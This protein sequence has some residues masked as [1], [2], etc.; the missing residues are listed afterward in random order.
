MSLKKG[1]MSK[2]EVSDDMI[3]KERDRVQIRMGNRN[4]L[5]I[6]YLFS[7]KTGFSFS[8][9]T[10]NNKI[11]RKKFCYDTSF[12]LPKQSQRSRFVL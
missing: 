7:Y 5:G 3:L 11:T 8:R 6:P 9:M 10:T 2:S 12:T 1:E 4:N